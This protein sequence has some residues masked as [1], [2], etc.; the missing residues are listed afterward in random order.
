MDR[1]RLGRTVPYLLW[2]ALAAWLFIAAGDVG[3]SARAGQIGP[4][5]WPRLALGL[6]AA[7]SLFEI[8]KALLFGAGPEPDDTG[9]TLAAAGDAEGEATRSLPLLLGGIGLILVY[10][11]LITTVGFPV[12]TFFFLAAFMYLGRYRN[13]FVIWASSA[14]GTF[15][16]AVVFLKVVYVSLPRGIAPFDQVT[17]AVIGLF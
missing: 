4:A 8:A 12:A 17:D 2:L 3:Y 7:A 1:A 16:I 13:H 9:D 10:G 5:F 6:I 11:M 15:V 14:I